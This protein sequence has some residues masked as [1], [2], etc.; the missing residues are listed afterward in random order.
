MSTNDSNQKQ[1][2][3]RVFQLNDELADFEELEISPDVKLHE[4]LN[5]KLI[6]YFVQASTFQS[7]I[8]AGSQASTRMKF[9]AADRAANVRD[10]IGPA[11]KIT[12]VDE[13]DE[14][15]GFKVFI[16]LEK[17]IAYEEAQ[18][19]PSYTGRAED[20]QLLQD[21]SLD[22]IIALTEKI[23]CPDGFRR[24]MI[25]DGRSIYGY[26][27]TYKEYMGEIIKERK[28]YRLQEN[29]PDGPYMAEGLIPRI[30]MSYNRVVIVELLRQLTPEEIIQAEE[31]DKKV[32]AFKKPA[33]PFIN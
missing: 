18:T 14:T 6:L 17:P 21:L 12:T 4:I 2:E 23:G 28:L 29:I 9:I 8:W 5:S 1:T 27:E 3:I 22:K 15:L 20:D 10:G 13:G 26:H 33:A 31:G 24:E 19:G 30:L 25:I 11:I 7:Y 16:G 32:E